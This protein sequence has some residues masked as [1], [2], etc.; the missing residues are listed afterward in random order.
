MAALREGSVDAALFVMGP[1]A[2]FLPELLATP[3]VRLMSFE[4]AQ[5]YARRFRYLS[6]VTLHPGSLDLARNLPERDV[7]LVAPAAVLVARKSVEERLS[8]PGLPRVTEGGLKHG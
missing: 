5:S 1:T 3:G 2:H 6:P 8:A 7:R 4:Q